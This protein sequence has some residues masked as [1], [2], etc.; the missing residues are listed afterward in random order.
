MREAKL[1]LIKSSGISMDGLLT[2]GEVVYRGLVYALIL[3]YFFFGVAI[4][5]DRFM[6]SIEMITSQ[7]KTVVLQ[8]E[9]GQRQEIQVK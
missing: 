2:G 1:E 8:Q 5:A 6:D 3:V 9:N 7:E 4:V